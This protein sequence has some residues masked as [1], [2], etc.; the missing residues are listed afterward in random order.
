[1]SD[2]ASLIDYY[3][4]ARRLENVS[5]HTLRNYSSD[6]AQFLEYLTPPGGEPPACAGLNTLVLREWLGSLYDRGLDPA[7]TRRKLAAVRSF[8]QWAVGQGV[9]EINVAKLLRTPKMPKKLPV[10]MTAEETNRLID[11]VNTQQLE[12]PY[13]A[14]DLAIFEFLYGCGLRASELVA[15]NLDDLDLAARWVLVHGKGKKERQVPFGEKAALALSKYFETRSPAPNERGV[16][17]N[18][19]G[20]RLS[21]RSVRSIVKFYATYLG[22]DSSLHP[23]SLRHAYATHLLSDGADLRSIQE[24]L[25][26]ARLSTTQRYTQVSLEDLMAVYDKAHPKA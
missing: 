11:S 6:L 26:H 2:L 5:A 19:R 13:P 10:V 9:I 7:S 8:L 20:R 23:H 14:R 25:G 18:H 4:D 1:M 15:M 22:G 3:L 16:F 12:R 24:L 17:L 21:D